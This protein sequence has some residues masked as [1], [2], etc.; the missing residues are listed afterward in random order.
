M[1]NSLNLD[2]IIPKEARIGAGFIYF[3]QYNVLVLQGII[4]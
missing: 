1:D 3:F 4:L 2:S